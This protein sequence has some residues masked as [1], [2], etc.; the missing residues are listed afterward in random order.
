[1]FNKLFVSVL[2]LGMAALPFTG[3]ASTVSSQES[4]TNELA[5]VNWNINI[6]TYGGP[7][8]DPYGAGYYNPYYYNCYPY[9]YYRPCPPPCP[10]Y[11]Y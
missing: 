3:E 6:N 11:W 1:M 10:Y 2:L 9:P 8:G 4:A 5:R 7:Y